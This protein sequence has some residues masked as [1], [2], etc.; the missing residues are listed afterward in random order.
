MMHFLGRRQ[1]AFIPAL[2]TQ[3]M[4]QKK[5]RPE[6]LPRATVTFVGIRV[7]KVS[8]VLTID[9]LSVLITVLTIGQPA[10]PRIGAWTLGFSRHLTLI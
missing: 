8:V 6:F 1:P 10:A 2:F 3:R 7:A 5:S 4:L 9:G